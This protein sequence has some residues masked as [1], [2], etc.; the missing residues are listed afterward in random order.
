MYELNLISNLIS[1]TY[2]DLW[3]LIERSIDH[4]Q[5]SYW[6]VFLDKEYEEPHSRLEYF[7]RA[8]VQFVLDIV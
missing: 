1:I 7:E 4:R 8:N 3:L 2:I 5:Q 6:L